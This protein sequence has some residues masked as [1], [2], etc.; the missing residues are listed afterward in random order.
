MNKLEFL[1]IITNWPRRKGKAELSKY[2]HGESITRQQ[3]ISAK[4]YD[5]SGG[6]PDG[7]QPCT[8]VSCPLYPH[9]PCNTLAQDS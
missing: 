6:Y 7:L 5:C 1:N 8:V 9:S 4:C 3:A 2:L